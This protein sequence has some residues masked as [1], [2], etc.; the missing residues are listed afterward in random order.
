[1][2]GKPSYD[3]EEHE[4]TG[5]TPAH[6]G[7]TIRKAYGKIYFGDHPRACGENAFF[8]N[9]SRLRPGS[10]P[11]MRGKHIAKAYAANKSRIT[12][13]H[14]G[15]TMEEADSDG[16][17]SDHPRAC[18][19][20]ASPRTG[21]LCGIGS[22][23][24]M[25]GK[26]L[27]HSC[28]ITALRITPAHAGKTR[29]ICARSRSAEDHPRACGE[30]TGLVMSGCAYPGSPPRMRGKPGLILDCSRASRITPAH[31]GKTHRRNDGCTI[32]K[33]HPRACGENISRAV[34]FGGERGSPPRMRGKRNISTSG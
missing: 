25:R 11:R 34:G 1:M 6:A 14:A 5:I 13:A 20:N 30:N 7:K 2:R 33:D 22:P 28:G 32:Y 18:G 16:G 31:A 21:M 27:P 29:D 19:E 17:W 3:G 24:R 9:L 23:P 12:P 10:P 4:V 26:R 15:K 8:A